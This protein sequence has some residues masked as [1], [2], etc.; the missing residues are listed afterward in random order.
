MTDLME[1]VAKPI[2]IGIVIIGTVLVVN[3]LLGF[4]GLA[5]LFIN[6]VLTFPGILGIGATSWVIGKVVPKIPKFVEDLL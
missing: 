3:Q 1:E 6:V 2:A 5:F 4:V